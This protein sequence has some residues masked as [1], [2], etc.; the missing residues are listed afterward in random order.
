MVASLRLLSSCA[1]GSGDHRL[2]AGTAICMVIAGW[3]PRKLPRLPS[4]SAAEARRR[5]RGEPSR[6][7]VITTPAWPYCVARPC[8]GFR[9]LQAFRED[10]KGA[11]LP[12]PMVARPQ[13]SAT[14]EP[15]EEA[16]LLENLGE[17]PGWDDQGDRMPTR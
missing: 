3:T 13:P 9:E 10:P 7:P 12:N 16:E 2:S 15:V 11:L 8:D 14:D 6:A 4:R 17:F 1:E 5:E